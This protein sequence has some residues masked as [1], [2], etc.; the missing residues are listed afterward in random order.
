MEFSP[1]T[2]IIEKARPSR[3]LPLKKKAYLP[4][5]RSESLYNETQRAFP[6]ANGAPPEA[7]ETLSGRNPNSPLIVFDSQIYLSKTHYISIIND[8]GFLVTPP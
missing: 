7:I 8:Y 3:V 6:N 5:A 2:Q 1:K 4:L